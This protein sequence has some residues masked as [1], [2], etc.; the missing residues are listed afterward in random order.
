VWKLSYSSILKTFAAACND[1]AIRIYQFN[2]PKTDTHG[3]HR[4]TIT[5]LAFGRSSVLSFDQEGGVEDFDPSSKVDN[6]FQIPTK[7]QSGIQSVCF[8]PQREAFVIGY[9]QSFQGDN[10]HG[11]LAVWSPHADEVK[12][13]STEE[14]VGYIACHPTQSIVAFATKSGAIGFKSLP[15][16][17]AVSGLQDLRPIPKAS[18]KSVECMLSWSPAGDKLL[19]ATVPDVGDSNPHF[20]I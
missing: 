14:P 20:S 19:M 2:P 10:H 8:Y 9:A 1:S 17:Q 12:S 16:L 11:G 13:C 4:N 18:E 15:E 7:F 6:S 5:C 3:F